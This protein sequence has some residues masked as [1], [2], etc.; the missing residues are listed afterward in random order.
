MK[1]RG[2][3]FFG[4]VLIIAV[5]AVFVS[6]GIKVIPAYLDFFSVT[7]VV[8]GIVNEPRVAVMRDSDIIERVRNQLSINNIRLS[9]L[10]RDAV[11][12]SR[13]DGELT[14]YID[15][16]IEEPFYTGENSQVSIS[17]H[18]EDSHAASASGG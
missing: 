15:Y 1:Q 2:F 17:M 3:S 4:V 7:S 18:F 10:G 8:H 11:T 12:V 13:D 6:V 9:D 16:Y 14:I 5:I